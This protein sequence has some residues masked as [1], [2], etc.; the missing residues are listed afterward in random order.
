MVVT[1]EFPEEKTVGSIQFSIPGRNAIK[2]AISKV[3]ITNPRNVVEF[4]K[5]GTLHDTRMGAF[6]NM[7]CATCGGNSFKCPGH[8]GHI[9]LTFPVINSMFVKTNLKKIIATTCFRCHRVN[10]CQCVVEVA[11]VDEEMKEPPK[12]RARKAKAPKKPKR[13][14]PAVVKLVQNTPFTFKTAG[15][16]L[17]YFLHDEGVATPLSIM[18]LYEHF[19]KVPEEQYRKIFPVKLD[20]EVDMTDFVFIH[21][22]LV[23]PISSRPPNFSGGDWRP[24]PMTRH[25]MDVLK[26]SDTL[27]MKR[28]Q[29]S[30]ELVIEYHNALQNAVNILFDIDDTQKKLKQQVYQ[31]GGMRQRLDGKQGRIRQ[32]LMGKRVEFSA[33]TVLSGDPRLGINEVGIPRK[34]AENLTFPEMITQYNLHVVPK[35]NIKY[36]YKKEDGH[37]Q[38]YDVKVNPKAMRMLRIGDKV[39][40]SLIDGDIVIVNRQP[41]LHRGSMVACYVRIFDCKTIRLN[42]STMVPLGADTDGDELNI[43]VPQ[44]QASR[45]EL[46]ELML[47]STNIVC[48][49]GSKPLFGC[50][51]DSLLGCYQLSKAILPWRDFMSIMY[52]LDIDTEVERRD[53]RGVEVMDAVLEHLGVDIDF[54]IIPNAEFIMKDSKVISGVFDKNVLG[55]ADN[56]VIHH[57]Y[58]SYDHKVA[59]KFI[60]MMQTAATAF[61]DIDGF[62]VGIGDCIVEHEPLHDKD[63]EK[64]IQK[65]QAE[66]KKP[67]ENL[68]AEATGSVIRLE[69]PHHCTPDNNRLLAMIVSGSKGSMV[70]FNQIT[71]TVGQQTVGAGRVP[72]EFGKGGGPG[73]SL[74]HFKEGDRGLY[75]GGYVRNSYVKGLRPEEFFFHAMG[76]RIGLIDTS[77]KTADTGA[78]Q[79]RLVKV[80][81]NAV[82]KEDGYGGRMVVNGSTGQII[83]FNYG[84]D[85]F[86]GTYLKNKPVD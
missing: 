68:L 81:E 52:E 66:G 58:L 27:R 51:Q 59:A 72:M 36:V 21:S 42:Y 77:C 80:L 74:P 26:A 32:N 1:L 61:L 17:S 4:D 11:E 48:S 15:V 34:F 84:E 64:M 14:K 29:A 63:L 37:D 82:I 71:R 6:R 45:A 50:T 41:T 85:D 33:R 16:K 19:K 39:E 47:A 46:E 49:Q 44:D 20:G 76:G 53:Y 75:A 35:W 55:K 79:R 9:D 83:Q 86:D 43:H 57:I 78:T 12:K 30:P 8:F 2:G 10:D 23:L 69:A 22:L 5:N 67:D 40:R 56:S 7:K 25:Y 13:M 24:D 28:N 73:R 60:H 31:N 54:L 70:N 3:K 18:D 65:E 38:R 62:S